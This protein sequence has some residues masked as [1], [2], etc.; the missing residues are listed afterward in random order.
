MT[1]RLYQGAIVEL[2]NVGVYR[3]PPPVRK[4]DV[5][6]MYPT[7]MIVGNLSPESVT[8]KHVRPYTGKFRFTPTEWEIPD[9]VLGQVTIKIDKEDSITRRFMLDYMALRARIRK[10]K[11]LVE[12]ERE[13]RQSAVKLT[14][15]YTYGYNGLIHS[16]YGSFLV[17]IASCGFGRF[18]MGEIIDESVEV[19]GA[20]S[21]ECDTDG[22]ILQSELSDLTT[23]LT[24]HLRELFSGWGFEYANVITVGEDIIDAIIMKSMKNYVTLEKGEVKFH[25]SAFHGRHMPRCVRTALERFAKAI[26]DGEDLRRVRLGLL[27]LKNYEL[28]DFTMNITLG[29]TPESYTRGTLGWQLSRQVDEAYFGETVSFVKTL[30]AY[31]ALGVK[32]DKWIRRNVDRR[33]YRT[34]INDALSRLSTP[35]GEQ[36]MQKLENWM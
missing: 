21:L 18:V 28:R 10:N 11:K 22:L 4:V 14:M 8:L 26:F 15:N 35:L 27:N 30:N 23:L 33:Y 12:V 17:A 3:S 1:Q 5:N 6:S 9:N 31:T 34:R 2:F 7:G 32:S 29:K 16:R 36:K 20:T 19:H 25:G 24:K 13:S